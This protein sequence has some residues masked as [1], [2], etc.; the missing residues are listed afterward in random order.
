MAIQLVQDIHIVDTELWTAFQ[1]YWDDGNYVAAVNLLNANQQLVTKYVSADWLNGLTALVYALENNSDPTFK[2]NKINIG[3]IPPSLATGGVYF[4]IEMG[5]GA[6]FNVATDVIS[7]NA[8]TVSINY[9]DTIVN[10]I[11]FQNL[12]QIKVDIQLMSGNIVKFSTGANPVTPINCFVFYTDSADVV[13]N[14]TLLSSGTS[15]SVSYS[16][17]IL[18]MY[19]YQANGTLVDCNITVGSNSV[20]FTTT[21]TTTL[22]CIVVTIDN[23]GTHTT[24]GNITT[25]INSKTLDCE[26]QLVNVI[27]LQNS[28]V[29]ILDTFLNMNEAIL[30]TQENPSATISCTIFYN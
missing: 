2:A 24:T 12:E 5:S 10:M 25:S 21:E 13:A 17:I 3:Y 19:A 6:I 26:G 18:S 15:A 11:A 1:D 8:T 28:D 27:A 23:I 14:Q 16:T 4:Q 22:T 9:S 29:V 30:S 20:T 7:T